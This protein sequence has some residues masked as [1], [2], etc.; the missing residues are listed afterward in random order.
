MV[1]AY[2]FLAICLL[3]GGAL[4]LRWFAQAPPGTIKKTLL[5][6][7]GII[8][9]CGVLVMVFLKRYQLA[10]YFAPLLLPF[11]LQAPSFWR[12]YKAA[13]GGSK[14]QSSS[15]NTRV[16]RMT[17]DHDS[18]LMEGEVLEGPYE[19][20]VLSELSLAEL[21][22]LWRYCA[23]ADADSLAVLEAYLDRTREEDWRARLDAED[24]AASRERRGR[25]GSESG[26]GAARSSGT[27]DRE[28]ALAVLGLSE[29]A[30]E[31][32]IKAAHRRLMRQV[33]PDHGGSDYLAARINEAKAVL[34]G[35]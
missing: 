18:G 24:E 8:A 29:G 2:V 31:S 32:D 10:L 13:R 27:M 20:R 23:E 35:H 9:L 1:L 15:V 30:T 34:L 17:L 33:H 25:Q 6:T 12:R 7:I 11:L 16:L 21:L 3:V 14:G 5:W 4:L 28:E 22:E 26:G 19:G